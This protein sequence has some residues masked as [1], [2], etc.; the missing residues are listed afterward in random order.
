M[1]TTLKYL[2]HYTTLESLALILNNESIRFKPLDTMDDLQEDKS[3]DIKNA[4]QF[5]FVSSWTDKKEESIPMWKM[6]SDLSCGVR[7]ALPDKP[8]EEYEI[9]KKQVRALMGNEGINSEKDNKTFRR[10]LYPISD[11]FSEDF[12]SPDMFLENGDSY[13]AEKVEYTSD[14]EKLNPSVL[15]KDDK[16]LGINIE[17]LGKYKNNAWKF[18]SEWRYKLTIFPGFA[19]KYLEKGGNSGAA[20]LNEIIQGKVKR[21]CDFYDRKIKREALNKM[22]IV[23]SPCFSAGN[24]V[25]LNALLKNYSVNIKVEE[26]ELRDKIR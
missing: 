3:K 11:I 9:T 14:E 6:Y 24:E 5:I 18:Q 8:F 25:L 23:K 4:G 13:E 12:F 10:S 20:I 19:K 26:S 16:E 2:Y 22:I 15:I 21:P 17:P 7:I 1:S